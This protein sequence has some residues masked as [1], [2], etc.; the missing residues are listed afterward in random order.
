MGAVLTPLVSRR[1]V[2]EAQEPQAVQQ[3]YEVQHADPT[4]LLPRVRKLLEEVATPVSVRIDRRS[5]HLVIE[6]DAETQ[7]IAAQLIRTLDRPA[8]NGNANANARDVNAGDASTREDTVIRGYRVTSDR[9]NESVAQLRQ[10]FGRVAVA[11]G[12]ESRTKQIVVNAVPAVQKQIAAYLESLEGESST[13]PPSR[14]P[15]ADSAPQGPHRLRNVTADQ[16]IASIRQV[17]GD[18]VIFAKGKEDGV[19]TAKLPS[20]DGTPVLLQIDHRQNRVATVG[21]TP[22]RSSLERIVQAIDA[23]ADASGAQVVSLSRSDKEHV[24]KAISAILSS[25]DGRSED[26]SVAIPNANRGARNADRLVRANQQPPANQDDPNQNPERPE[27]PNVDPDS[28]LD[29]D[30]GLMGDVR[31]EFIEGLDI[32]IIRGRKA[33]VERVREMIQQIDEISKT[34]KP[35]VEVRMLKNVASTPLSDL[36]N[37]IYSQVF[38]QRQGQVTILPLVKPNALLLIGR[39]ENVAEIEKLIEQLD[40][41]AIPAGLWK[42]FPLK[43]A[44]A[45]DAEATIRN[46][47][48]GVTTATGQAGGGAPGGPG[49][50]GAPGA[51]GAVGGGAG[52]TTGLRPRITVIADQRS[53]ALVVQAGPRDLEE[54]AALITQL[55]VESSSATSELRVFKLRNTLAQELAPVLQDALRG[56]G[57]ARAGGQGG[58]GGQGQ[59]GFQGGQAQQGAGT[60]QQNQQ[61]RTTTLQLVT[62]DPQGKSVLA[63]GIATDVVVTAD[64]TANA[65]LVRAPSKAM[66]LIAALV[67]ELDAGPEAAAKI[68]VFTIVNGDATYLGQTL[69]QLFGQQVTIGRG[70][71]GAFGQGAFGGLG[72]AFGAANQTGAGET[73]LVPLRF[74][75]DARTNSIIA[76]GSEQDLNVVEAILFRLDE[77]TGRS[78][79]LM[80]FRLKNAFAQDVA[81]AITNFLQSQR[82]LYQ[83]DQ[84]FN[85]SVSPWDQLERQVI[86]TAE[87][88]SNSVV[89]SATPNFYEPIT[90]IINELDFRPSMVMVQV[91]IAEVNL[92]DVYEFGVE[93]GLQDSLIFDRGKAALANQFPPGTPGF[94][95]NNVGLTN[96]NSR[97]QDTL[98]GSG[99]SAFGLGRT[100][101]TLGYGGMVLSAANESINI[102]VRALQ[103]SNRLQILSRPQVMAIHNRPAQILVGQKVPRITNSTINNLGNTQNTVQ[104]VD[105]GIILNIIPQINDDGVVVLYVEAQKSAVGPEEQGIVITTNAQGIPVRSPRID[106]TSAFTTVSAK[107]GQ[108]VVFAGLITSTKLQTSRGVPYLSDIPVLGRLFEFESETQRRT[109]LL[110]VM[111]PKIVK[112]DQDYD[113][114]NATESARMNW[115]LSDVVGVHGDV[116]L[117]GGSC[118]F[119]K[120]KLPVIYPDLDPTGSEA[121][122]APEATAPYDQP[123]PEDGASFR[124]APNS[125][126]NTAT[127]WTPSD[128]RRSTP[129]R[130]GSSRANSNRPS[131]GQAGARVPAN[132]SSTGTRNAYPVTPA[133]YFPENGLP[134]KPS[135]RTYQPTYQGSQQSNG[136]E[137]S[138]GFR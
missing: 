100:N 59:P 128:P 108:T 102:L 86:V 47:F 23:P 75:I 117:K 120:E 54:V 53:N 52:Q 42:V 92:S 35:K 50:A 13:A 88:Q 109:E 32:Y 41:S 76:T 28:M 127:E 129:A 107:D 51:L 29:S 80:V 105:V 18:L 46:L 12:T 84:L 1:Y 61:L 63:S 132:G 123:I 85:Q 45:L 56:S 93:L 19:S 72:G 113:W 49:G 135:Q 26:V 38:N 62:V 69:Q 90:K 81:T 122:S 10:R 65:L 20:S 110:I 78:R 22:M 103:D 6:G 131:V 74:A 98:A 31:I 55:D 104:D 44:S 96:Q 16:L 3:A 7:R 95:F 82:T 106:T 11:I 79:K 126:V 30:S 115:C 91:L 116:G 4:E 73:N 125:A 68:K 37:Q 101:A 5:G 33:D 99:V 14:L 89:V 118:L 48:S 15:V 119:C 60:G 121:Y 36:L 40:Q 136:P 27:E 134:S 94:N 77:T 25:S 124:G 71:G 17:W 66:E 57:Q 67:E 24:K 21:S 137:S 87:P 133:E 70:T 9:L 114:I 83:Q 130:A 64:V 2:I 39:E 112:Y 58:Q 97:L 111:T 8:T 34:T 138:T 43:H